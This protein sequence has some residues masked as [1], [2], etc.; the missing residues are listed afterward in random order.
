MQPFQTLLFGLETPVMETKFKAF[1]S[2]K[3][4]KAMNLKKLKESGH[5]A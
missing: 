4:K 5:Y 3:D 2:K 1:L